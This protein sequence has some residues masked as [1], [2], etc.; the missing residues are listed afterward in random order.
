MAE[1]LAKRTRSVV[2]DDSVMAEHFVHF[3]H[4]DKFDQ[5]I[6]SSNRRGVSIANFLGNISGDR[7]RIHISQSY[8]DFP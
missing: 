7:L 2:S 6:I 8:K 1:N 3:V 5:G 4:F